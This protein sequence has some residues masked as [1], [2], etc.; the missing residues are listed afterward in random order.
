MEAVECETTETNENDF[1]F[2][3]KKTHRKEDLILD[4]NLH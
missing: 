1:G 4:N 3:L 2:Q